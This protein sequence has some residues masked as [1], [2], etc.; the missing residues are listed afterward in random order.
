MMREL[1]WTQNVDPQDPRRFT[2]PGVPLVRIAKDMQKRLNARTMRVIGDPK[3]PI[4][5]A[6]ASWGYVSRMPGIA[7]FREPGLNLFIGGETREWELVEYVQDSIT[8]GDRKAMILVGHVLSEQGG[9]EYCA[10]W[11]KPFIPEVPVKF[12]AAREPFWN[13]DKPVGS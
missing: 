2:F 11:L 9:M 8:K 5:K 7:Q 13:P 3:L 10:E 12:V 1:G 4:H 6:F